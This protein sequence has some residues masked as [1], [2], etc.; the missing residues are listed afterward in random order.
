MDVPVEK[1]DIFES[2][3]FPP[4]TVQLG[5]GQG[6]QLILKPTPSVDPNDPLVRIAL[7]SRY[8]KF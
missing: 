5:L 8:D 6:N 2:E 3:H 1:R 7:E 4:G